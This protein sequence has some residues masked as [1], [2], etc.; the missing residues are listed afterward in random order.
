MRPQEAQQIAP[1]LAGPLSWIIRA[2]PLRFSIISLLGTRSQV[3]IHTHGQILTTYTRR[4]CGRRLPRLGWSKAR[5]NDRDPL[6]DV[7]IWHRFQSNAGSSR[8][9]SRLHV[10][11]LL[12]QLQQCDS[13]Y[14]SRSNHTSGGG[15]SLVSTAT[16]LV[17]D[18]PV[19]GALPSCNP[20]TGSLCSAGVAS[21]C[22][23]FGNFSMSVTIN[24]LLWPNGTVAGA[25]SG[26]RVGLATSLGPVIERDNLASPATTTQ[27]VHG[28]CT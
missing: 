20:P 25:G 5:P 11:K 18:W 21:N 19:P 26:V 22:E 23:L 2:S 8:C 3:S 24:L 10:D 15:P 1:S 13:E 27:V 4:S 6:C 12:R 7:R 9:G 14:C 28:T 16:G 17:V